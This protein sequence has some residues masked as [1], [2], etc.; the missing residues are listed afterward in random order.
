[1]H[2]I[3][4]RRLD[5][6]G[7]G[8]VRHRRALDQEI[9]YLISNEGFYGWW[10]FLEFGIQVRHKQLRKSVKKSIKLR[11]SHGINLN[12]HSWASCCSVARSCRLSTSF[13]GLKD[14]LFPSWRAANVTCSWNMG[15]SWSIWMCQHSHCSV[16]MSRHTLY[17]SSDTPSGGSQLNTPARNA[18][19]RYH[20]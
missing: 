11:K 17:F 20:T 10:L 1:M 13:S 3:L 8:G 7:T 2:D 5:C 12:T 16:N 18:I 14:I 15:E 6:L 4:C 9:P 19:S